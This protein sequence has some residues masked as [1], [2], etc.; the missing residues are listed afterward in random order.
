MSTLSADQIFERN[1]LNSLMKNTEYFSKVFHILKS[2]YFTDNRQEI[3]NLIR[4]HFL[5]YK[6]PPNPQDVAIR[7]KNLQS[8]E[9]KKH[10]VEEIMEISKSEEASV[11]ALCDETLTFVKDAL[12]LKALEI[13]SE[14][15]MLKSDDLKKKA[16]QILEER[17]KVNIASDLGLEL[18]D[19]SI[20]DYYTLK[21]EGLLT[22]HLSLNERLGPGFL[23]KT[24]S[25][26]AAPSGVGKSLLMTDLI[27][28]FVKKGKNILLVSLE[29]SS[30][31]VMKRVH[32]NITNIPI[33]DFDPRHFPKELFATRMRDLKTQGTGLFYAKDY[34]ALS[35]SSLQLD[36][37]LD[38]FKNEKGIEFDGVFVDYLGIMKSDT[39]S[40][41]VGLYSYVKGIAEELR[42]V[43]VRRNISI[44][45]ASQLNRGATNN[46]DA[47]NSTI[48]DSYGTLMTADFLMFLLQTEEM[49]E[50]GDIIFKITKNRFSGRTESF[51][52]K[53]NYQYMRFVDADI[54]ANV[55][56]QT[57]FME[58]FEV[59]KDA[60][61]EMLK[62]IMKRDAENAAK[63]DS[64]GSKKI[65]D[66]K[67]LNDIFEEL[68]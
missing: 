43:A 29:M 40:P 56:E 63:L 24:L 3:F 68:L 57:K 15:L 51:P 11:T 4:G 67:T 65:E 1:V 23:K 21:L 9:T 62:D 13:G 64:E 5:E 47:D 44:I 26:I 50:N 8:S 42:A 66:I 34:P 54:P 38:A 49:K 48:S 61:D 33:S 41:S 22:Q 25:L 59:N 45:S 39:L 36:S 28:G 46:T 2:D 6:E 17:A 12:Y 7:V 32:S 58:T 14:G 27:T 18:F 35:F 55:E 60:T 30:E 52:M 16:E 10:I 37:L 19:D 20:I 31:E 53:V